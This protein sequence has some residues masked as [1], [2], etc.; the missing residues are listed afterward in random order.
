MNRKSVKRWLVLLGLLF[1]SV[2]AFAQDEAKPVARPSGKAHSLFDGKALGGWKVTEFGDEG[3]VEVS[4]GQIILGEGDGLTGVT[5]TL[6]FPKVNYEIEFDA[7][8]VAGDDFF[9]G[10]T[11]PYKDSFCSFVVG[12]WGGTVVGLSSVDGYD[13]SENN[14]SMFSEFK[15]GKWYH[16]RLRVTPE[17]IETWID[18]KKYVDLETKDRKLSVRI[19]IE[20]SKPLGLASWSTKAAMRNI[21][22][23]LIKK[24]K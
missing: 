16:I 13:A 15:N 10:L 5:W 14:T 20:D 9:C 22:Y 17:K 3:K 1:V 21:E 19:D 23:R 7:M 6:K 8:R 4:K 11:F 18:K 12:G 2:D 24:E